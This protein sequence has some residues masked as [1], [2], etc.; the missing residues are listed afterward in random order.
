MYIIAWSMY[1]CLDDVQDFFYTSSSFY[2]EHIK[3]LSLI[4]I[5]IISFLL[6]VRK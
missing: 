5:N 6:D 4:Y 3:D 2:R 1:I